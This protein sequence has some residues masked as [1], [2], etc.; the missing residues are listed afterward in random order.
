[1]PI[2]KP[3]VSTSLSPNLVKE[4]DRTGQTI[5]SSECAV[6]FPFTEQLSRCSSRLVAV[7]G[8]APPNVASFLPAKNRT[9]GMLPKKKKGADIAAG[10]L[11]IR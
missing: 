3:L 7:Q 10:A 6:G 11:L 5:A 4:A 8:M 2:G 1:L 9:A